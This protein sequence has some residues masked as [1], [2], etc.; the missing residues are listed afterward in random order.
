M[1]EFEEYEKMTPASK[2]L[3][4]KSKRLFP[5]GVSH[6]IRFFRPHP[7]FTSKAQGA[8]L[9]DEDGNKY[10]DFWMGHMACILGHAHPVVV[11]A[12]KEILPFGIHWGTVNKIALKLAE[13]VNS[14]VPC[15]QMVRFCNSGT[16]A[17]MYATR[18]AR[19]FTE[20]NKVLKMEGGWH[21][22]NTDLMMGV[23]PPYNKPDT[24]GLPYKISDCIKLAPF[25]DIQ[26]TME[27]LRSVKDEL[28][29]VIVEPVLGAGG[30]IP[31]DKEY[32]KMLREMTRDCGALLIFD[33][34]ITGFRLGLGGAQQHYNIAP[35]MATLGKILGGGAPIG[36]VVGKTKIMKI[37]SP[38][39]RGNGKVWIGG[40]TFSMNPLTM[41]A[42]LATLNF[43]KANPD[44][45]HR[46]GKLGEEVRQELDKIFANHGMMARTTGIKSLFLIHFLK[47]HIELKNPRQYQDFVDREREGK[48]YHSLLKH[49]IFFL[50]GHS[51]SIS[52]AHSEEEIKMLL[53]TTKKVAEEI[54]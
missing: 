39:E 3:H 22:G 25:N 4:E 47:K 12:I 28:A 26:N 51:G 49:G 52:Y 11:K 14:L 21:G 15:A 1:E 19:A 43:L 6:N 44:I 10:I 9:W 29:C 17:T 33:E 27:I 42:G 50:P 46:I 24:I 30:I 38:V 5:G 35:D 54:T 36:A 40:G 16:E 34:V 31:A 23:G 18:I 45:Y 13:T 2:R 8:Y 53:E 32:L 48:Y 20:R 41:S 37:V 7:F